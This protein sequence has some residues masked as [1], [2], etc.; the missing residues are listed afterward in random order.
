M[1]IKQPGEYRVSM[2]RRQEEV[3]IELAVIRGAGEILTE[4]GTT[5]VRAG[6][7]VYASAGLMP[8]YAYSYNSANWDDFDRWSES[9]RSTR[10]Q[11][12]V[13]VFAG[14]SADVCVHL[15]RVR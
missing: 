6:E 1:R 13:A 5:E 9:L 2:L 11:R 3:Q 14:G 4:E 15:R 7:R 12:V 8:L 10:A